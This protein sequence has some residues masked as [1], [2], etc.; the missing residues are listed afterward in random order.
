MVRRSRT[1]QGVRGLKP[2]FLPAHTLHNASH[3]ARSA[4]IETLIGYRNTCLNPVAPSRVRG[5]KHIEVPGDVL[6]QRSHPHGC[7]D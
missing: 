4:W 2:A 7:V 5:L 3:S 6:V 1:P